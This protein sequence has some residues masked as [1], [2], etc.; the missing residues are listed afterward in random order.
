[1]HKQKAKGTATAF[2]PSVTSVIPLS[3]DM[4]GQTMT[5]CKHLKT[6]MFSLGAYHPFPKGAPSSKVFYQHVVIEEQ[7][8]YSTYCSTSVFPLGEVWCVHTVGPVLNGI[9]KEE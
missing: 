8:V 4:T 6:E 3:A 1:M 9:L 5:I 7:S 2:I